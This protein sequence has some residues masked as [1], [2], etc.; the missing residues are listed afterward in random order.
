M[1]SRLR[2]FASKPASNF[3]KRIPKL[4]PEKTVA[5]RRLETVQ[6]GRTETLP[7]W[8]FEVARLT[9][10]WNCWYIHQL[11]SSAV[12]PDNLEA[13]CTATLE[14]KLHTAA[15][16]GGTH[17]NLGFVM[18]VFEVKSSETDRKMLP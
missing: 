13:C 11:I 18:E 12:A 4:R 6:F 3:C 15:P 9:R 17:R 14:K 2:C 7:P 5:S 10:A 1:Y 16:D 8:H